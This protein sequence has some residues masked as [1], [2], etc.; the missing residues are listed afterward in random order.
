[1]RIVGDGLDC[2]TIWDGWQDREHEQDLD[3]RHPSQHMLRWR[4]TLLRTTRL[5]VVSAD[6][7]VSIEDRS[8]LVTSPCMNDE[9]T[10]PSA[11][12]LVSEASWNNWGV[13]RVFLMDS[14]RGRITS[15]A[16]PLHK[17]GVRA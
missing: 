11:V 2:G 1:M 16:R 7:I 14:C 15:V 9:P 3:G 8:V 5:G 12:D 17:M 13:G 10:L 6:E 4:L